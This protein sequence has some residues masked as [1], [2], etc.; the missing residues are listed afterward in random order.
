MFSLCPALLVQRGPGGSSPP[1]PLANDAQTPANFCCRPAHPEPAAS[2]LSL[3]LLRPCW[4]CEHREQE[5]QHPLGLR[6]AGCHSTGAKPTPQLTASE[7]TSFLGV[8]HRQRYL[9]G[10]AGDVLQLGWRAGSQ[11][12]RGCG[13]AAPKAQTRQSEVR[14]PWQPPRVIFL[15]G[16]VCTAA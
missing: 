12:A 15:L 3:W 8:W 2:P 5:Q 4:G 6:I 10:G 1:L 7:V 11:L 9:C 16:R 14:T 13:I